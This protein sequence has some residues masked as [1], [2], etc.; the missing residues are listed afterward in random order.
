[1]Y[2]QGKNYYSKV[3]GIKIKIIA[4]SYTIITVH[5]IS[6]KYLYNKR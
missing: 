2:R 5:I 1:M 4:N 6:K 3:N